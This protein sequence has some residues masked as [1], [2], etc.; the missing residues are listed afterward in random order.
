LR[1]HLRISNNPNFVIPSK[2]RN[3]LF[4][5][6]KKQILR[7]CAPEVSIPLEGK[8]L[9][10]DGLRMTIFLEIPIRPCCCI[11]VLPDPRSF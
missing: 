3:L 2:A 5:E 7:T 1:I 6:N 10:G 8:V 11:V 9:L 4:I